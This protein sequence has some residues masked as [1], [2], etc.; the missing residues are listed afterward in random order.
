ME[1]KSIVKKQPDIKE[2]ITW[3]TNTITAIDLLEGVWV[4]DVSEDGKQK[5]EEFGTLW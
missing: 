5:F 4:R 2:E 3:A 1:S